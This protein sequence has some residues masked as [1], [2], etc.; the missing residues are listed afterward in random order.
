MAP[1]EISKNTD[2]IDS[3]IGIARHVAIIMDGNGRWAR[4]RGL[5]RTAGHKA[6]VDSVKRV[7]RSAG[8]FGIDYLTL[9]GFSSENWS[10]P[11]DE[12]GALMSMLRAFLRSEIAQL[13]RENVQIRFIGD[14]SAL[15]HDIVELI[16][17]AEN[18]TSQNTSLVVMIALSYGGRQELVAAMRSIAVD[19]AG[20]V[21]DP[22]EI[23]EDTINGR[24]WT[25]GI[26]DPDLIIRTSGEQRISNFLLWQSAYSEFISLDTLWP[27]FSA[28]DFRRSLQ[29]YSQRERRFGDVTA[30]SIR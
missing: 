10:R 3:L 23:S 8:E 17:R 2:S 18:M 26:P 30:R 20:G 29:A 21:L 24:L 28:D 16:D 19:V 13:H 15:A 11:K 25:R 4:A 27:D 9:F 1:T 5:P 7:I 6:G 22:A 14:R 12:V